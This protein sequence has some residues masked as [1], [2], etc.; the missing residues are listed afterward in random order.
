MLYRLTFGI[1]REG[2]LRVVGSSGGSPAVSA[3]HL[4]DNVFT[5]LVKAAG[6]APLQTYRLIEAA[7]EAR[8]HPED[9]IYCEAVELTEAQ[10]E[11]LCLRKVNAART[12]VHWES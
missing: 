10:L 2:Y 9:D 3:I 6:L 7:R 1:T 11:T 12:G 8:L 5:A 4:N